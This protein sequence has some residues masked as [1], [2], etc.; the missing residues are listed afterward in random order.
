MIVEGQIHGG[1]VDGIGMALMEVIAF[2]KDGNCLGGSFMDY[3][4][5][6]AV[7]VPDVRARRDRHA[8]AAP[9]AR[10]QGRRRVGD[11]RFAAGGGERRDRRAQAVRRPP[12]RHAVHA[13]AGVDDDAGPAVPDRPGDRGLSHPCPPTAPRSAIEQRGCA[14]RACRTC[15]RA[16]CWR[17]RPTSAKPGDEAL[18]LPDGT[19]EGF[20]G[21]TCAESTVLAQGLALHRLRRVVAAADHARA[22]AATAGQARRA[23]RLPVGR[24]ARDL[25]RT[26]AAG[27]AAGGVRR[28][29]G[30][31]ARSARSR[32]TSGGTFPTGGRRRRREPGSV[33]TSS[34]V[35]VA[36]HGRDEE[37]ALT[38]A[39]RAG[40]PYIGLVASRKRG[41]AVL[42]SLDVDARRREPRAHAR[43]ARHRRPLERRG[44]AVDHG[45]DR[46]DP[47]AAVR[48]GDRRH[49]GIERAPP[50]IRC[51]GCRSPPSSRHSTSTTTTAACGSAAAVACAR[52]PPT[53]RPTPSPVTRP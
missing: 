49:H 11:R 45:R 3:L 34:A 50:P 4:L 31:R 28:R 25:P 48:A 16:S 13:G 19:I 39:L 15:T 51:A 21:G 37:V 40:V 9:S 8:V 22:G 46:V 53:R 2:D 6:T 43:R 29:P 52:S 41:E 17:K 18:V 14:T 27:A 7:E 30:G 1:L 20:V 10:L 38:A 33:P 47:A 42:A 26:G 12:R 32:R 35:V 44:R 36:S 23:Q 24:H 5:P